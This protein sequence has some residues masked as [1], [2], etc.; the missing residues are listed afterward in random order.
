MDAVNNH[1][2]LW[3]SMQENL[4][5]EVAKIHFPDRSQAVSSTLIE[6][7]MLTS[8]NFIQEFKNEY[9]EADAWIMEAAGFMYVGV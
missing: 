4:Y 6:M 3:N 1:H 9:P 2:S 7:G 8:Q 5:R